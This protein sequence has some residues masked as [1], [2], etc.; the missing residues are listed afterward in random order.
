M[1]D[2][3]K[4]YINRQIFRFYV[5]LIKFRERG[6]P[7]LMLKCINPR[8]GSL[9]DAAAGVHVRFRLGGPSF[10]PTIFYKIFCHAPVADIGAFAPKDYMTSRKRPTTKMVHNNV[11]VPGGDRSRW[12]SRVDN[13]DW[14]P[15]S[16]KMLQDAETIVA[17]RDAGYTIPKYAS[18]H[19]SRLKRQEDV[20]LRIKRNRRK[21][22]MQLYTQEQEAQGHAPKEQIRSDARELFDSLTDAELDEEVNRLVQWT[23]DLD[24]KSY[25]QD[26]LLLATTAGSDYELQ[27][28]DDQAEAEGKDFLPL[29]GGP[30][31]TAAAGAAA[32][33]AAAAPPPPPQPPA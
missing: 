27:A 17:E 8:E 25:R 9:M 28:P 14:R 3:W 19:H 32:A 4:R 22:L 12:Y 23:R 15:I 10:P 1:Q 29:P 5:D 24:F 11:S 16:D 6:D 21:W 26:W 2:A 18:F 33:D 13:N 7:Q 30:A 20:H 31:G